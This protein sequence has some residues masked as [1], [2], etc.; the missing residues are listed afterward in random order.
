M[1]RLTVFIAVAIIIALG[2]AWV[3]SNP[4][5]VLISW[6]GWEVRFSVAVSV[7][8]VILYT[9]FI[10]VLIRLLK[11]LNITAY[12]SSPE[13]L[14]AKRARAEQDLDRAWSA[15]ALE[16]YA[17]A[18]KHGRRAKA[19]LGDDHNVLRL[20]ASATRKSGDAN[21]PYL[22]ALKKSDM[23]ATWVEKQELDDLLG[24]KAWSR[25]R[26]LIAN[27]L[28]HNPKN[29]NLL[30]LNL[31]ASAHMS[32]WQAAK[33]AFGALSNNKGSM[34][35]KQLKRYSAVIDYSLALEAKAAGQKAE[36][37][38]LFKS[39][40]KNDPSF[41]AAA[42]ASARGYIEQDDKKSAEKVVLKAW[43]HRQTDELGELYAELYPT[44]SGAETFRR[45][46]K[47]SDIVEAPESQHL[48][49]EAAIEAE[50]W[51]D[52]RRTL[53]TLVNNDAASKKTYHLMAL[54][55]RKQK[56]DA[57]ASEKL[58]SR[59]EKAGGDPGWKCSNCHA[60]ATHYQPVCPACG[61]FDTI[62]WT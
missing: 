40:L 17:D 31:I 38:D 8:L 20:L 52:A 25:A 41:S 18:I 2:A 30:E 19:K 10:L 37:H 36:S 7:L 35:A 62:D 12:F 47:L 13:R 23:S 29:T 27:M 59:A 6:Q 32:D 21:N 51:P 55:E 3:S 48:L 33:D 46:K 28:E 22:D 42:I 49:A 54:L 61:G 57:E 5:A 11:W 34:D 1:I 58:L 56:K 50:K 44:E 26:P 14:A 4:G 24:E 16:D 60:P 53:E 43:K 9:G 15:Y 39:A 45:V